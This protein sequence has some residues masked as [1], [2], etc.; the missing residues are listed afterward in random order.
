M[1]RSA[2]LLLVPLLAACNVHSKKSTDAD[3]NVSINADETGHISFNVP[4]MQGQVKVPGSVM[5]GGDFDIDGVKLMPGS[6]VTGFNLTA[7]DHGSTVNIG[8]KAPATVEQTRAYFLDQFRQKGVQAAA[9]GDG[10]TGTSKDGSPFV[11]HL[12]QADGGTQ[13]MIDVQDKD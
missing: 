9:N 13:G 11:I 5:H 10:I 3:D 12:S 7:R 2:L 1:N 4:F 6:T 8:F